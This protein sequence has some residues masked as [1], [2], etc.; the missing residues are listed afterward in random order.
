MTRLLL[1]VVA[2]AAL[3]ASTGMAAGAFP[4]DWAYSNSITI[5]EH[6]GSDLT[7]YQIPI[8]LNASNFNFSKAQPDGADIRFA[9]LNDDLLSYWVENWDSTGRRAK[10]WVEVP[11]IPAS[12]VITI[13]MWYGNAG[14]ASESNFTGTMLLPME[15][16]WHTTTGYADNYAGIA[17]VDVDSNNNIYGGDCAHYDSTSYLIKF[18]PN[19]TEMKSVAMYSCI[20]SIKIDESDNI[21]VS[22]G[23]WGYSL[24][25]YDPDLNEQC[26][27]DS[28]DYRENLWPMKLVDGH[29]YAPS[30]RSSSSPYNA[31]ISK[32]DAYCSVI[33]TTPYH[34]SYSLYAGGVYHHSATDKTYAGF[35]RE[36]DDNH[37]RLARFTGAGILDWD[38]LVLSDSSAGIQDIIHENNYLYISG[39]GE[40]EEI[41]A[42]TYIFLAK[43]D[44][45]GNQIFMKKY[46]DTADYITAG[47]ALMKVG[48]DLLL[49]PANYYD[50]SDYFPAF[51]AV[52]FDGNLIWR[53][54]ISGTS[55]PDWK[56][57]GTKL[58]DDHTILL[59]GKDGN[60]GDLMKVSYYKY[61]SP[62]PSVAVGAGPST[63][64]RGD[65]SD[66]GLV[67]AIDA[68][69]VAQY[70]A[71]NRDASTL[72]MDNADADLNGGVD[73][74]DA[75]FIAQYVA[76]SR[77]W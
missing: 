32:F 3:V 72:D 65:A 26:H 21:F 56:I 39:T 58:L 28:D 14:A 66:D 18:D 10:V 30:W 5:E 50:G 76:G 16:L 62:K 55:D 36:D 57:R 38:K 24:R 2:V 43:Y 19:G 47:D 54:Y 44:L 13:R 41:G 51:Y 74:V 23:P 67:N 12:D 63:T 46:N 60:C 34:S 33:E 37:L 64:L 61:T 40:T 7:D 15:V 59:G 49:M 29:I 69:F 71:G 52:D 35:C 27:Y 31:G 8:E 22:N 77:W 73:V 42:N 53:G 70:T 75:M 68:M 4:A 20:Q 11:S 48:D 1:V 17:T 25:V 9:E 45:D 6:S